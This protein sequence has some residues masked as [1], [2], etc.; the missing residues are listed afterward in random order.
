MIPVKFLLFYRRTGEYFN[1]C[2]KI[3]SNREIL[4]SKLNKNFNQRFV[5]LFSS[6]F[7]FH[8]NHR[9]LILHFKYHFRLFASIYF[10]ILRLLRDSKKTRVSYRSKKKEKDANVSAPKNLFLLPNHENFH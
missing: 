3:I 7:Q 1:I 10:K 6:S 4:W 9:H 8:K 2:E 5:Y